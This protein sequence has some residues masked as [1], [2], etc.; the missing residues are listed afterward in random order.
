MKKLLTSFLLILGLTAFSFSSSATTQS[1]GP[2]VLEACE[3]EIKAN[4]A[5]VTPGEGRLFAC[6]YAY[7]DQ[8]S[9][10][11]TNAID[12]YADALDFFFANANEALTICAPDIEEECAGERVGGGRILSCLIENRSDLSPDCQEVTDTF[13]SKFG[14]N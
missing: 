4:C 11:C 12:D 1:G 13:S 5:K 2:S 6:L 7:E 10:R 3:P 8:V 14:M 9:A